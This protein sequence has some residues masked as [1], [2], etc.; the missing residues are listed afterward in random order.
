[1]TSTK[2]FTS[3]C[4]AAALSACVSA[5]EPIVDYHAPYAGKGGLTSSPVP[6][7]RPEARTFDKRCHVPGEPER[8]FAWCDDDDKTSIGKLTPPGLERPPHP[9]PPEKPKQCHPKDRGPA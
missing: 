9:E 6:R 2:I 7:A 4:A 5:P 1:M 8:N 3:L